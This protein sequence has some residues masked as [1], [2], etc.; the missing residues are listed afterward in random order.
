MIHSAL[1]PLPSFCKLRCNFRE[2][3]KWGTSNQLSFSEINY[4]LSSNINRLGLCIEIRYIYRGIKS[5]FQYLSLLSDI[6]HKLNSQHFFI[7]TIM[8]P[9]LFKNPLGVCDHI[10]TCASRIQA[11]EIKEGVVNQTRALCP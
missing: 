6:S 7:K 5:I 4:D 9:L 2:K 1:M 11:L 3:K 8:S 10:C